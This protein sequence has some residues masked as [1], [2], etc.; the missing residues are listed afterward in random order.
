MTGI[1]AADDDDHDWNVC[2]VCCNDAK[3]E[4]IAMLNL[5]N[6]KKRKQIQ[7]NQKYDS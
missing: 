7:N 4:F 6:Q 2:Y 5:L 1:S 3:S